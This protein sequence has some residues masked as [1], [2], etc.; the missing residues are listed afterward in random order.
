MRSPLG[1]CHSP[2]ADFQHIRIVPMPRPGILRK[3]NL[4]I[5]QYL[6]TR[7]PL[8]LAIPARSNVAGCSP[9]LADP[10]GP[11]PRLAPAP[12]ADAENNRPSRRNQRLMHFLIR[13]G[14]LHSL[15]MT[16]I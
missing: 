5:E 2:V 10:I 7:L 9:K 14:R 15:G 12:F 4:L 8:L 1:K 6:P 3:R 11:K 16:P 13:L